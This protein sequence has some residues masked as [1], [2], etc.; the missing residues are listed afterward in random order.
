MQG[1]IPGIILLG[2]AFQDLGRQGGYFV[3]CAFF[4]S[5]ICD[6]CV[7]PALQPSGDLQDIPHLTGGNLLG[8]SAPG[9]AG[10]IIRALVGSGDAQHH[11][12]DFPAQRRTP[13]G[14]LPADWAF[15]EDCVD[16]FPIL[17]DD[18]TGEDENQQM[19]PPIT[20]YVVG[21]NLPGD[22]ELLPGTEVCLIQY[23]FLC[24]YRKHVHRS[25]QPGNAK[26]EAEE[27]AAVILMGKLRKL[28]KLPPNGYLI[29]RVFHC[30]TPITS[31][32]PI[33]CV[34]EQLRTKEMEY[35]T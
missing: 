34:P 6:L 1:S 15:Q 26:T 35:G 10:Q 30:I 8:G 3:S 16:T 19:P 33:L 28:Q 7:H 5:G 12:A 17:A 32:C 27:A 23:G 29:C 9:D 11:I 20:A 31:V 22:G 24:H 25:G 18:L 21:T 2:T 14:G 13:E 4:G